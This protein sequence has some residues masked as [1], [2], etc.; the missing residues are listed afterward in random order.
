MKN[1]FPFLCI[2]VS[3]AERR[4]SLIGELVL[5]VI[6]PIDDAFNSLIM[7]DCFPLHDITLGAFNSELPTLVILVVLSLVLQTKCGIIHR[8]F[9]EM[10]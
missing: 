5:T 8:S 6:K 1:I 2:P 9:S 7:I 10:Y 4:E 3:W